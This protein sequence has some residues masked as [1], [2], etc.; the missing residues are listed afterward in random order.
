MRCN[1]IRATWGSLPASTPDGFNL[2]N[3]ARALEKSMGLAQKV[4]NAI[5]GEEVQ[6]DICVEGEP[7]TEL[8]RFQALYDGRVHVVVTPDI[9]P[10][11]KRTINAPA[12]Y[13]VGVSLIYEGGEPEDRQ[14]LYQL[15]T[16]NCSPN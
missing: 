5:A 16:E 7:G 9:G 8:S 14:Q 6:P 12:V 1:R 2:G 4:A 15:L 10:R 3:H 13:D 11:G